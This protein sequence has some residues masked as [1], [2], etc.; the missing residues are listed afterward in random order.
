MKIA[1]YGRLITLF[2]AFLPTMITLAGGPAQGDES[3]AGIELQGTIRVSGA[4]ALYPMMVKWSGEFRKTCQGVRI[5]I[6]AGGAGKG[7]ADVLSGLVD[8]GM[9]SREVTPEEVKRGTCYVPV[10][11][12]AVFPTM[13]RR[14]PALN[15]LLQRGVK[16]ETFIDWW[17]K[18]GVLTWGEAAG[19]SP[20]NT[21]KNRIHVYTR[22][23]S[24]GAAE[25]WAQYLG[26]KNQEDLKGIG[27]YG[28]PGLAEVVRKDVLGV[29]YNNLSCAYDFRTALPLDGLVII[30]IDVN[31]NGKVDAGE[32]LKTKNEAIRAINSGVY[33][34]PPARALYLV[35]KTGFRGPSKGFIQWILTE[36]QKYVE[37]A[38]Y[39]RLPKAM[40]TE[41][42]RKLK[43]ES[44]T[45]KPL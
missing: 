12:D 20:P 6:S 17:I 33:P 36:G 44:K 24:C 29:G 5:D 43:A 21:V 7:I 35:T 42:L 26:G 15:I 23:D 8:I 16:K 14:N 34:S 13:N 45:Q 18:G 1:R 2:L 10:V 4:W 19:L 32:S 11:R 30:P 39:I 22:S 38:G 40:V 28:D 31:E 9:V 37:E 25:T 41:S 3:R 27:V